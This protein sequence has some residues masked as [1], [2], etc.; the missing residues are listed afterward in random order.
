MLHPRFP[1]LRVVLHRGQ[2]LLRVVG[3][4]AGDLRAQLHLAAALF[5]ELTHLLAGDFRQILHAL[6]DQIG[7]LMQHRQ[8]LADVAFRPVRMIK[9][10]GRL[11]AASISASVCEGYS[12][13]SWLV[14]GFTV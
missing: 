9:R 6:V 4:V 8:A 13:M 1:E 2:E 7:K 11:S 12:L 10:I 5:D 14:A 3:V